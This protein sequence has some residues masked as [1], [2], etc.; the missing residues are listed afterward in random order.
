MGWVTLS[1]INLSTMTYNVSTGF[2][3]GWPKSEASLD[4]TLSGIYH[5]L[6]RQIQ[7]EDGVF[8]SFHYEI[9]LPNTKGKGHQEDSSVG[10]PIKHLI[11]YPYIMKAPNPEGLYW[12]L[13]NTREQV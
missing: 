11:P 8:H 13:Y 12:E 5:T 4:F 6:R 3:H 9:L 7:P 10:V 1:L 2:H